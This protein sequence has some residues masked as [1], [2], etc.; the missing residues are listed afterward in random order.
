MECKE[1][2]G[3]VTHENIIDLI[4]TLWNVKAAPSCRV[5]VPGYR[6]NRDIVECKDRAA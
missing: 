1:I 4:E 3:T 2:I 5:P 6:F